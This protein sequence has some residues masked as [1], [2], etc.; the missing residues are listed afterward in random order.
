MIKKMLE[1]YVSKKEEDIK[2]LYGNTN[3]LSISTLINYK[4]VDEKQLE[5]YLR[6]HNLLDQAMNIDRFKLKKMFDK[7]ELSL[8]E[9]PDIIEKN[10]SL[11]FRVGKNK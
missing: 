6:E 7:G 10:E 8:E 11:S 1:E 2:V 9:L 5:E 4:T 3:K